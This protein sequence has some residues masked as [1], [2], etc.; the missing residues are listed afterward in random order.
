MIKC[1][2]EYLSVCKK[3]FI[4]YLWLGFWA[5]YIVCSFQEGSTVRHARYICKTPVHLVLDDSWYFGLALSFGMRSKAL[6]VSKFFFQQ[7]LPVNMTPR[8]EKLVFNSGVTILFLKSIKLKFV[9]LP[10][11]NASGPW[12]RQHN[13]KKN[14]IIGFTCSGAF[15]FQK[16]NLTY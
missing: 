12:N 15:P 2:N 16:I 3:G 11:W 1:T 7:K 9:A 14:Q 13:V 10:A 8:K 4:L 6:S 5:C